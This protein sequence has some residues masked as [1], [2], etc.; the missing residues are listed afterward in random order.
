MYCTFYRSASPC[1]EAET[2]ASTANGQRPSGEPQLIVYNRI[3]KTAS[4]TFMHLPYELCAENGFNV[5]L[6]WHSMLLCFFLLIQWVIL[7]E[8]P[9]N[10]TYFF[11]HW[12][13]L[14]LNISRPQHFLTF[15]DQGQINQGSFFSQ[16]T[17]L[18]VCLWGYYNSLETCADIINGG[19]L[20][21]FH[22]IL[23]VCLVIR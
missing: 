20:I 23:I 5:L 1:R 16:L 9:S 11:Q 22:K 2:A 3:P 14:Q 19:L 7:F 17:L 15:A 21:A 4:T 10:C 18:R 13:H 12:I 8:P 6:G